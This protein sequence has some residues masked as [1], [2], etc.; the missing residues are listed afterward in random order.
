LAA[1]ST[2]DWRRRALSSL[3]GGLGLASLLSLVWLGIVWLNAKFPPNEPWDE[4][5]IVAVPGAQF[6]IANGERKGIELKY[7]LENR[8]TADYR[9]EYDTPLTILLRT[10][11]DEFSEPIHTDTISIRK[12]ILIPAN[13]AALLTLNL[14]VSGLPQQKTA[15]SDLQY[16]GEVR[17]FFQEHFKAIQSFVV[18]DARPQY[19]IGQFHMKRYR[20]ILP[21][22]DALRSKG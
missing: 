21:V 7:I 5:A 9:I 10:P 8:T 1:Q 14:L 11:E 12:P 13:Q 22:P 2:T 20:V 15:E 17:G 3:V 6:G 16:L 18:I 4:E 19:G